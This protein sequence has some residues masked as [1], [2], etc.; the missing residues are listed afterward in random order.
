M[1]DDFKK[2]IRDQQ[3]VKNGQKIL[4]GISGGV[5]SIVLAHLFLQSHIETEWAH[6][7][8]HLRGSESDGDEVFV[9]QL[10][11]EWSVPLHCK[12]FN[13]DSYAREKGISIQM[14]ARELRFQWFNE[15]MLQQH[16]NSIATA[17][18]A[19]D[20]IETFFVNLM[21]GSGLRGLTGIAPKSGNIVHPLLFCGRADI[22][23]YAHQNKLSFR[24]DSSNA[25]TKYMR[26]S[27][28]HEI[29]P[30]F[31]R[32]NPSFS[33]RMMENMELLRQSYGLLEYQ[34]EK[35]REACIKTG[36]GRIEMD[37][38]A[39]RSYRPL[40]PVLHYLIGDYGFSG[41]DVANIAGAMTDESGKL[42]ASSTH[43]LLIDRNRIII[44]PLEDGFIATEVFL[45]N[46]SGEISVP[47]RLKWEVIK[48]L[49]GGFRFPTDNQSHLLNAENLKWPLKLRKW[50][51]GDSFVPFGMKGR[52]K[53]SDFLIDEKID[54]FE[55]ERVYV[56]M[57]G[58]E[59][60]CIPGYRISENFR[61][62]DSKHEVLKL[63][64]F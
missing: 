49:P 54:R 39:L 62:R 36:D 56:L 35:A 6:C 4:L 25:S 60:C 58:N 32:H 31:E 57:A 29:L 61:I 24:E 51:P 19:G 63:Q 47:L 34:G 9:R 10:A 64:L 26:N 55:K 20:S 45:H 23:E 48:A 59:I 17:H 1:L 14:A 21:R 16:C 53:I 22:M 52:K 43:R 38:P 50:Q 15:L 44:E 12:D 18:H 28:R 5:D 7:N 41:N 30:L 2:F 13:T 46:K 33:R 3:L 8:F 27:I 40:Q 37:V 11:K 42:F